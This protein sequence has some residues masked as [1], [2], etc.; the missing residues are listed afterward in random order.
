ASSPLIVILCHTSF[1]HRQLGD[2]R[3]DP[4]RLACNAV[5]HYVQKGVMEFATMAMICSS[6]S[7]FVID[8]QKIGLHGCQGQAQTRASEE[9]CGESE[10]AERAGGRNR[11]CRDGRAVRAGRNNNH[12]SRGD[13][14]A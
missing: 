5:L 6:A 7:S 10:T 13:G 1:S 3:C 9:S 8:A 2:I 11:R 12:V 4:P 14:G